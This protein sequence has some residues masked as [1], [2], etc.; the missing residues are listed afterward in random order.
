MSYTYLNTGWMR[1]KKNVNA[2]AYRY[3]TCTWRQELIV[4]MYIDN[5][6]GLWGIY[7]IVSLSF[8]EILYVLLFKVLTKIRPIHAGS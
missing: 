6:F 3:H 7:R 4:E 8:H 5:I 1:N 2:A